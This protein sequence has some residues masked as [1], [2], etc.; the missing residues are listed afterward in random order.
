MKARVYV[1]TTIV[2]YLTALPASDIVLAAHQLITRGWWDR[3]DR[4][5]EE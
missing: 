1:E 3:R 2:S 5:G 4:F